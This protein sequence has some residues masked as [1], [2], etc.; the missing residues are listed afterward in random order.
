MASYYVNASADD[1]GDGTTQALTGANCAWNEIS[2]V[3]SY[4]GSF[5][6]ADDVSLNR[7]DEW[8]DALEITDSGNAGNPITFQAYGTGA[9]PI[10]NGSNAL[11]TWAESDIEGWYA[12]GSEFTDNFNDN[13]LTGW[14]STTGGVANQNGR[15]EVTVDGSGGSQDYIVEGGDITDRTEYY[16]SWKRYYNAITTI[17]SGHQMQG[18]GFSGVLHVGLYNDGGTYKHKVTT[19]DDSASAT[20][21]TTSATISTGQWYEICIYWKASTGAGNDDGIAKVWIDGELV[22]DVSNLDTDTM[23]VAAVK[24]GNNYCHSEVDMV[25]YEDDLSVGTSYSGNGAHIYEK[26]CT[27]TPM[28]IFEDDTFLRWYQWDTDISTTFSGKSAGCWS[29]SGTTAYVWCTDDADPDT[30]TMEVGNK[31]GNDQYGIYILNCSYVTIDGIEVRYTTDSNIKVL[32]NTGTERTINIQN[33]TLTGA[34]DTALDFGG[35]GAGGYDDLIDCLADGLTISYARRHGL[36]FGY[37]TSSS[38]AS[39]SEAHHCGWGG[40]SAATGGDGFSSWGPDATNNPRDNI[41]EFLTSHD[42][43]VTTG[44]IEG[45]GCRFD[46]YT[47]DSICRYCLCYDNEGSGLTDNGL[48]G[49]RWYYNVSYGNGTGTGSTSFNGGMLFNDANGLKIYN[50]VFY[51]NYPCGVGFYNGDQVSVEIVNN[52]FFENDTYEIRYG[53]GCTT[54]LISDYN[55][56]YHSAG[57]N[58]MRPVSATDWAGWQAAGWDLRGINSDPLVVDAAGADFNLKPT[59]PCIDAGRPL[60]LTQDYNGNPVPRGWGVDIGA[61]EYQPINIRVNVKTL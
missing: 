11:T 2:D 33:M 48:S 58:F 60:G 42:N 6:A 25:F 40:V 14:D 9:D 35:Q 57:G 55:C 7:G 52:I 43:Y 5:A 39:N 3:N 59:S 28:V 49:D 20:N 10:I 29:N 26:D 21:T 41:F 44:D 12:D 50:N 51:D 30:H 32:V 27:N 45:K 38:T 19:Y 4:M 54:G 46:N 1:G 17:N 56:V 61:C 16:M 23:D 13:D 31:T 34:G 18:G 47:K 53:T 15:L 22:H 8:S 37:G 24:L 36:M